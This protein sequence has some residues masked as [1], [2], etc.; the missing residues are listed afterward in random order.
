MLENNSNAMCSYCQ[1]VKQ[2]L[3]QVYQTPRSI[4]LSRLQNDHR[5][6]GFVVCR[7]EP[8]SQIEEIAAVG[9][10]EGVIVE[11][12][13]WDGEVVGG[14]EK[15][16]VRVPLLEF[17]GWDCGSLDVCISFHYFKRM[18][19]SFDST[20]TNFALNRTH[21]STCEGRCR[22]AEQRQCCAEV[23]EH[24]EAVETGFQL[25]QKAVEIFQEVLHLISDVH[26]TPVISQ[27]LPKHKRR[28]TTKQSILQF[29]MRGDLHSETLETHL[30]NLNHNHSL[31]RNLIALSPSSSSLYIPILFPTFHINNLSPLTLRNRR[32]QE[33]P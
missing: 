30:M 16:G 29:A 21:L 27:M 8:V 7:I 31:F 14:V 1:I 12:V 18:L 24:L 33:P 23:G 22:E 15:S 26:V 20:Y 19:S 32:S 9:F 5:S 2:A 25:S 4:R 3:L 10:V 17:A 11:V 6:A 28:A 13:D